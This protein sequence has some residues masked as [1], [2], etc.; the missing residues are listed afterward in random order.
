MRI[1]LIPVTLVA[2]V[3]L[4]SSAAAHRSGCHR[5]HSC[6]SDSGSYVCGDLGY[7]NYCPSRPA[8][9]SGY[10]SSVSADTIFEIQKHLFAKGYDTGDADGIMGR[11]TEAAIKLFQ[12]QRGLRVDGRPSYSLLLELKR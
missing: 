3:L 1:L 6:P 7:S 10:A 4:P 12:R 11:K 5:W 8:T 2:I 9:T